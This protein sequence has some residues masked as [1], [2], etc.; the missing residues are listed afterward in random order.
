M[1]EWINIAAK[2][3]TQQQITKQAIKYEEELKNK[4]KH[5]SKNCTHADGNFIFTK[6]LRTGNI[7]WHAIPILQ[8][9]NLEQFRKPA[10]PI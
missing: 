5:L 9:I 6:E 4:L 8:E 3:Y 1:N 2:L 10:T 7:D